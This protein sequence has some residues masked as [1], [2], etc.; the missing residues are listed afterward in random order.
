MAA[1]VAASARAGG[2]RWVLL[3]APVAGRGRSTALEA[4][5][6]QQADGDAMHIGRARGVP[7][8]TAFPFGL[9]RQLFPADEAVGLFQC[10]VTPFC[11]PATAK[12]TEPSVPVM[13]P[14]DSRAHFA[15]TP[16]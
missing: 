13:K 7:E 14:S 16:A 12:V 5:V 8:E 9:V 15:V 6:R 11:S 3:S 10:T 1:A 2:G 4:I